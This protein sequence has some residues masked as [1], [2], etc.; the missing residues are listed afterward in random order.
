MTYLDE[1][2]KTI[3]EQRDL[4]NLLSERLLLIDTFLESIN[5]RDEGISNRLTANQLRIEKIK[6]KA[7]ANTLSSIITER[8]IYFAKYAEQ[9]QKEYDE[10]VSNYDLVYKK[11][12]ALKDTNRAVFYLL[13]KVNHQSLEESKEAKLEFYKLLKQHV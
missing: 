9:F 4:F 10:M 3:Q 13:D 2:K 12:E 5:G 8:E 11:A 7:E 1:L 6:V